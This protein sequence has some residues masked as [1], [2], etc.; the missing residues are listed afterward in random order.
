MTSYNVFFTLAIISYLLTLSCALDNPYSSGYVKF[1]YDDKEQLG[2]KNWGNL[3]SAFEIC[4][5]GA[6]Q[7]PINIQTNATSFNSSIESLKRDY[8][9]ANATLINNGHNIGLV[10]TSEAGSAVIDGKKYALKQLRWHF[11]SEHTID[12]KS[13]AAEVHLL[14]ESTDGKVAIVSILYNF[15]DADPF[16]YQIDAKLPQLSS[17]SCSEQQ[18]ARISAGLIH[19]RSLKVTTSKYYRYVGSLTTP[20]CTENIIWNILSEVRTMSVD[21]GKKLAASYGGVPN[22][23]PIQSLNGRIVQVYNRVINAKKK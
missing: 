11:P 8:I 17:E 22:A 19:S 21:Q 6:Q 4:G 2:S 9:A 16:L 7:S 14:H 3:T 13:F 5:K 1:S 23:R 15:G 20:P 18:E 12:G 10:Y